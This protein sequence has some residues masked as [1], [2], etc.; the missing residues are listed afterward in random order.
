MS[1]ILGADVSAELC[2]YGQRIRDRFGFADE[3]LR[4]AHYPDL[5][6]ICRF[7][8]LDDQDLGR[9]VEQLERQV[10]VG[11][12]AVTPVT[13]RD[14]E[15]DEATLVVRV[16]GAEYV[17]G[18][19]QGAMPVCAAVTKK[20]PRLNF[21]IAE[22]SALG[23][24]HAQRIRKV[25]TPA[26]VKGAVTGLLLARYDEDEK[27]WAQSQRIVFPSRRQNAA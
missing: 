16:E 4:C 5:L 21:V 8:D 17:I 20:A 18:Y 22:L 7:A 3:H 6:P 24:A 25:V 11:D 1:I 14:L 13:C 2:G 23:V 15:I 27:R 26:P 10:V 12:L 19:L 9:L